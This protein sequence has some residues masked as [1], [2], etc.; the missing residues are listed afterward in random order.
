MVYVHNTAGSILKLV[1][2]C[3][4]WPSGQGAKCKPPVSPPSVFCHS[5]LTTA[6][7]TAHN[8]A[9][10]TVMHIVLHNTA[11][12]T[13]HNNAYYTVMHIVLHNTAHATATV[14]VY[15][16]NKC[17]QLIGPAT[18]NVYCSSKCV[19]TIVSKLLSYYGHCDL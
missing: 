10:F 14:Y 11:H 17:V 3:P 16:N 7:T 1:H 12:A 4:K 6:H 19:L 9:D 18:G 15:C 8:N 13:A 5:S 2:L